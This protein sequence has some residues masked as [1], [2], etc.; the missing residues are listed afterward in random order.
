MTW[1]TT[2]ARQT[3]KLAFAGTDLFLGAWPG[4]RILGY[5]QVGTDLG[6][7]MEVSLASFLQHLDWLS[8]HGRIL[9]LEEA[10]RPPAIGEP[11]TYVLTFDDGYRDL[12]EVA[13]PLLRERGLPFTLYLATEPVETRVPLT[14]GGQADPL[15]WDQIGD[16]LESGLLTL[17]VHTH[18]HRDLRGGSA[19]EIAEELDRSNELVQQRVGITPRHFAYPKGYWD[20]LAEELVRARYETAVLGAGPPLGVDTDRHRLHRMPIQKSDGVFFF[21]RKVVRGMRLEERVRR[22]LRGYHG[23]T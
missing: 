20:P 18:R 16:M 6:R 19:A 5:H 11:G 12:Y 1:L 4:A 8:S 3:A 7:Q 17:G 22:V 9:G 14:P 21:R 10:L 2:A 23:P 15:S 13:F